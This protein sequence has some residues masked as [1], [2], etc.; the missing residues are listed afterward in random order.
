VTSPKSRFQRW[1]MDV[2]ERVTRAAAA[3][4]AHGLDAAV[5]SSPHNVCYV[6]GYE[7]PIEAGPSAFAGGPDLALLDADGHVTL[8]VPD[9]EAGAAAAGAQVDAIVSYAAFGYQERYDQA[10]NE[11]AELRRVLLESGI[12]S[13]TLGVEPTFLPASL[14]RAI[15]EDFA[16]VRF[17]DATPALAGAR[18]VKTAEEVARLRRAVD[19]T[20]VGQNAARRHLTPGMTEI[21]LFTRVRGAMEE[22]AGHRLAIAGDLVAGTD[23]TANAG[24]WPSDR[25]ISEG[26][27]VIVDLAPRLDGYWGDSCNSLCAGE[28]T[29][30]FRR[31]IQATTEAL[32]KGIEAARPGLQAAELDAICR[33]HVESYGYAYAHHSGHALGTTVHEDPRLVPYEPMPLQPGMVLALEPAAYIQGVGGVRTEHVI[34]ITETGAEVLSS[35]AHGF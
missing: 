27:L 30:E 33:R 23:R 6:S 10:A 14:D 32:A 34:L 4:R 7:V 26:S 25:T 12:T 20:S 17:A 8:I 13:G 24:G 5:L 11:W 16:A 31:M 35:F 19:L 29:A 18:L 28:P 2:N 21:A 3:L 1:R 15:R 9:L 22:A